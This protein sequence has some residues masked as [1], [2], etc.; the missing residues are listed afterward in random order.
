LTA[1][2]G[3]AE[4]SVVEATAVE[5]TE[6]E[7]TEAVMEAVMEAVVEVVKVVVKEV[8]EAVKEEACIDISLVRVSLSTPP[9]SSS[10][11]S[12]SFPRLSLPRSH[13]LQ[14]ISYSR[15]HYSCSRWRTR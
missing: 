4:D 13:L 1:R 7:A 14:L 5:A 6:E 8:M 15:P 11:R 12:I 9:P 3:L 10:I 2:R